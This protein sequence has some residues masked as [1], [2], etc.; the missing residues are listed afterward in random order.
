MFRGVSVIPTTLQTPIRPSTIFA[1][2]K[3]FD[4][5]AK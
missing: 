3:R 2:L 1:N 4:R 5:V